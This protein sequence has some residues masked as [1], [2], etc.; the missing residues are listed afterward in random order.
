MDVLMKIKKL[1]YERGWTDYKLAKEAGL[2]QSTISSM[3]R[4]NNAPTLSTLE[5][6][7]NAFGITL[8]QF[9]ADGNVPIDL[10]Q[11]QRSMLE[12]W[13]MLSEEQKRA[14]FALMKS[15]Q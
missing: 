4:K 14:L 7:C 15:M 10:T 6:I 9:F 8:S 1:Q 3:F 5:A 12:N 13:N 2:Q 11:E